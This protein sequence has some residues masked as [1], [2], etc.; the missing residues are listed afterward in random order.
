MIGGSDV[1]R[2]AV[3]RL[4]V[5]GVIV[6]AMAL[7]FATRVAAQDLTAK[8]VRVIVSASDP[9]DVRVVVAISNPSMYG[10][11]VVSATSDAAERVEL[12]DARKR[13]AVVKEVEV[14]AFGSLT[15]EPKGLY[16]KLINLKRPLRPGTRVDVM[17]TSD[18]Q[19]KTRL[20][21]V[22]ATP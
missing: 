6:A 4:A 1:N 12:R 10:I 13:D 9:A 18:T 11:Y 2:S 22:V 8:N 20:S 7:T 17:L 3:R 5:M 15:L 16:L 14:P 21:A 19:A